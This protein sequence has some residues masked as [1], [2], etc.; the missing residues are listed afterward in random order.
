MNGYALVIGINEYDELPDLD[1]AI[2]DADAVAEALEKSGF[3]VKK[4]NGL[5]L[6]DFKKTIDEFDN[7]LK[8]FDIG[9][10]YFA[11]HG[12]QQDGINFLAGK[13]FIPATTYI[14]KKDGVTLDEVIEKMTDAKIET[15]IIILDACRRKHED[16][17]R[18]SASNTDLAPIFAPKGT[19]VAFSTSP[20]EGAKDGVGQDH[21]Y[22]ASAFL[23]HIK[24]EN[25]S[26]E[27]FFK[28]V[29][30]T[31]STATNGKQTS[32]EHTS[33]IGQFT[34]NNGRL[35]HSMNLPYSDRVIADGTFKN[36]LDGSETE[37]ALKALSGN[38]N[39]QNSAMT[40]INRMD[41]STWTIDHLFLLGRGLIGGGENN[42]FD[43]TNILK[44]LPSW[45]V[46]HGKAGMEH[47]LNGMLYEIYFD[48][49]GLIRR[50][51]NKTKWLNEIFRLQDDIRFKKSFEMIADQLRP[52]ANRVAYLP[53]PNQPTVPID[54]ATED[55]ATSNNR[56]HKKVVSIN[57]HG[58]NITVD[59]KG[60][61][62]DFNGKTVCYDDFLGMLCD[63]L[64]IPKNKI[65]INPPNLSGH[66]LKIPFSFGKFRTTE[67][68]F[69]QEKP[70]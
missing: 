42:A 52:F 68:L 22:Y 70:S 12:F 53:G 34:F 67:F 7:N 35:R 38:F 49:K 56:S 58:K 20:G 60:E 69:E 9:L 62:P 47:I 19:L 44:D 21:S 5:T 55:I 10:F 59:T 13:E 51:R 17:I 50:K 65:T 18:G 33:L 43:V 16:G 15:K 66:L 46:R 11:G 29:R 36:S 48:S 3:I 39:E 14:M 25:I 45:L 8:G 37:A 57:I 40:K 23:T 63:E 30:T 6:D 41:L 2:N 26:I 32:W 31:L 61:D 54:L 24:D 28:R 64:V 4:A 1:N 27:E